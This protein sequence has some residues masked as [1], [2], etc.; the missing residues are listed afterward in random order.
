MSC[1]VVFRPFALWNTD[2]QGVV[3]PR[4]GR[5][6][7]RGQQAPGIGSHGS[8]TC[9]QVTL[10]IPSFGWIP[11]GLGGSKCVYRK[12]PNLASYIECWDLS[13]ERPT[14]RGSWGSHLFELSCEPREKPE[15]PSWPSKEQRVWVLRTLEKSNLH[16]L[17]IIMPLKHVGGKVRLFV[18]LAR[19]FCQLHRDLW[20]IGI[21]WAWSFWTASF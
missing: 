12:K 18:H 16:S 19:M 21:P 11:H 10:N 2:I 17:M 9:D 6:M 20:I 15:A 13:F 5:S 3:L 14:Q 1:W 7:M 4:D 8:V